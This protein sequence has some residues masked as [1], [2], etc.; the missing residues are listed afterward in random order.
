MF[1]KIAITN[2]PEEKKDVIYWL[3]PTLRKTISMAIG[4]PK[5]AA[6]GQPEKYKFNSTS[7][8]PS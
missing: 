6:N 4:T 2:F 8:L 1:L 7:P 5:R 3:K